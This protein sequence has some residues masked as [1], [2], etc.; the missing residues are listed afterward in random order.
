M[1]LDLYMVGLGVQNMSKSLEFYRRLGLALPE[2]GEEQPHI[3][4]KM[5][6]E[7]TF[8]LDTREIPSDNPELKGAANKG[9]ILE[10]YL[11]EQAAVDA[12]YKELIESGYQSYHTPFVTPFGIYFALVNDPDG[13]T[14]LLSAEVEK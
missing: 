5:G 10:F 13:N 14:I 6:G 1:A 2:G 8:F 9:V 4:V 11:K 7:L 3:E 12:K